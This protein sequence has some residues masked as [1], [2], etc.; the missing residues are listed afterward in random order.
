MCGDGYILNFLF[1]LHELARPIN[2]EKVELMVIYDSRVS[3]IQVRDDESKLN[4]DK[5]KFVEFTSSILENL[6]QKPNFNSEVF[7]LTMNCHHIS[8][9]SI[10][11]KYMRRV[12]VIR[13]LNK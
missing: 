3:P 11:N 4:C 13:E 8:I 12:R 1:V 7:F 2:K 9:I 5:E 6:S 10:I